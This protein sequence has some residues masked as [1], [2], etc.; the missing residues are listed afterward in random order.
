VASLADGRC[1]CAAFWRGRGQRPP[2]VLHEADG[3]PDDDLAPGQARRTDGRVVDV[4]KTLARSR[5]RPADPEGMGGDTW[6]PWP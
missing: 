1:T 6:R 5:G 3:H 2:C 4:L